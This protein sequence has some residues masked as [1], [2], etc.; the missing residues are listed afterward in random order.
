M[1][2]RTS[3]VFATG[4]RNKLK[5]VQAILDN[6]ILLRNLEDINC[7]EEIPET[8]N[9]IELNALQK[10]QYVADKFGVNCFAEDTGLEIQIL[11][12]EPGV[13]SAR[14]AGLQKSADDNMELVLSK[15][16]HA[17][18]RQARFKTVVALILDNK[19]FTFE[20]IINGIISNE[21]RGHNGFGY[22]PIF[23]PDG[24]KKT[25]AEL[26]KKEKNSISHRAVAISKFLDFINCS[27]V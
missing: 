7:Y 13:F 25:F 1:T 11:N 19:Q 27:V 4:N 3:L 23:I 20:G 21:K 22:D 12:G 16:K 2:V 14:Y 10:A 8:K 17:T 26:D 9:T 18:N 24:Y 15:M 5:E 6:T